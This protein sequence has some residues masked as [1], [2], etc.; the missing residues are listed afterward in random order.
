MRFLKQST[1]HTDRIGPFLDPLDGVTP[2]T[3]LGGMGVEISKAGAA[4]ASRNSATATAH[5]QEGFYSLVLDATDTN[6][7]GRL[8]VKVM[9]ESLHLPVWIEYT[10]L[11]ANIY[12]SLIAGTDKLEVDVTLLNGV[13]AVDFY[14]ADIN[15]AVDGAQTQDEYTVTWM[16]NGVPI[17]EAITSPTIQVTKRLDGSGLIAQ[18]AMTNVG[19]TGML[20]YTTGVSRLGSGEAGNVKVT[21]S[22][23]GQTRT[24]SKTV[25]RDSS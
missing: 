17:E 4:F 8:L 11:P 20:K 10:V 1:A 12:D 25:S 24:F 19:S 9:N 16:K 21:A 7:L 5:D 23:D 13:A 22:I 18:T 6:T 2:V 3:T 15:F 14:T